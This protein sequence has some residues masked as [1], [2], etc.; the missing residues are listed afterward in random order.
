M[1]VVSPARQGARIHWCRAVQ[2]LIGII[3]YKVVAGREIFCPLCGDFAALEWRR[4]RTDDFGLSIDRRSP[5]CEHGCPRAP[6]LELAANRL[7]EGFEPA[8]YRLPELTV[9]VLAYRYG[10]GPK[11]VRW[12]SPCHACRSQSLVSDGPEVL[13]ELRAISQRLS[14]E[15][16][17]VS[18]DE[19][20]FRGERQ[21]LHVVMS[22][23]ELTMKL[24]ARQRH[25]NGRTR[26]PR[27]FVYL[28][29]HR[30]AVKIGWSRMHPGRARI[31]QLQTAS[32]E[33]L[34]LIGVLNGT[35]EDEAEL[36]ERF[37]RNHIRG[38]WFRRA[39]EI[40][41]HF[42]GNGGGS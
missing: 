37:M 41:S 3:A 8:F 15:E 27:G 32:S 4:F 20:R 16:R 17:I 21:H 10:V 19:D 30:R 29:G 23:V 40:L 24:Q 18:R 36:H 22:D 13:E 14:S 39:E 35:L 33:P 5:R 11:V 2:E 12:A 28:I 6:Y 38:E 7:A 31:S 9:A 25:S 1:Q 34:E 42:S 26:L